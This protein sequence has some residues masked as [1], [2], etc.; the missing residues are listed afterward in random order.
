MRKWGA[1]AVAVEYPG[2]GVYKDKDIDVNDDLFLRDAEAVY[3]FFCKELAVHPSQV[4]IFGRS[5]GSGPA[6]LL[7]SRRPHG[8]LFLFSPMKSLKDSVNSKSFSMGGW[9]YSAFDNEKLIKSITTPTFIIHGKRDE[10][11]HFSK[12]LDLYNAS[13]AAPDL[14]TVHLPNDMTHNNF[15]LETD[16][17]PASLDF[18]N[19][20]AQHPIPQQFPPIDPQRV[21]N[22][23]AHRQW[24]HPQHNN[25]E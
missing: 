10:V 12:S 5:I 16:F 3:D 7:A 24:H 17:L 22:I 20:V 15:D 19:R 2:Y 25:Q 9:C 11:I 1:H 4:I 13:G 6:T 21:L 8:A 18:L 23:F 14:K